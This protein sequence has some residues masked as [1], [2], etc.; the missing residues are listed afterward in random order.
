MSEELH[1][2]IVTI[3]GPAGSGKS[4]TARLVAE[5]LGFTY[6]DTGAMYRAIALKALEEGIDVTRPDLLGEMADR[7]QVAIE[8]DPRGTRVMLD[9][10][11]V[12]DMLRRPEVSRSASPVSAAKRVRERMVELQREIGK[13]GPIVAEGRDIGS[14]VFPDAAVK[15]YLDAGLSC[16]AARRT[17]ELEAAGTMVDQASI[18]TEI[19]ARDERDSTRE[20][21]PLVVPRGAV[22]IDSTNLTIEQ[23]VG[24]VIEEVRKVAPQEGG[25]ASTGGPVR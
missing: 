8:A 2:V 25:A 3:D 24:R 16:R 9:G 15:I 10:R 11:D 20:N 5:K 18:E 6:L 13:L 22:I 23:Q 17:K 21:S 12:T 19:R 1:H 7:T 14:V 4:T